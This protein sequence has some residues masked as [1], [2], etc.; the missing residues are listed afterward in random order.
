MMMRRGMEMKSPLKPGAGT[1]GGLVMDSPD[2]SLIAFP[3]LIGP[4]RSKHT[5]HKKG[6]ACMA[7]PFSIQ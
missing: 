2:N 1:C 3:S 7:I 5:Q 6:I 4:K